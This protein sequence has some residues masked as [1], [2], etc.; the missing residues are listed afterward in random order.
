MMRCAEG[1][2]IPDTVDGTLGRIVRMSR[3]P[4]CFLAAFLFVKVSCCRPARPRQFT[5]RTLLSVLACLPS[6]VI[7][8]EVQT[9]KVEYSAIQAT[10]GGVNVYVPGKWGLL[11]LEV[12]NPLPEPHELL[13]TT[14]FEG[15]PTLQFGRRIWVP[16]RS[17]LRTW[18]P[19]LAPEITAPV[20]EIEFHSLVLK[21]G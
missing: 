13:S 19:V 14:Y 16:A 11:N 20:N 21:S 12:V 1:L 6:A 3:F 15:Q 17:R 18:Q 7:A 2:W 5:A 4:Y 8:D 9:P 10:S